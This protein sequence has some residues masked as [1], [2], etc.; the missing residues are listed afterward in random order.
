MTTRPSD[1]PL[2]RRREVA[3]RHQIAPRTLDRALREGPE[4]IRAGMVRD[5]VLAALSELG[6][7]V[8]RPPSAE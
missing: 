6:V 1:L 3:A 2:A 8:E 7:A 5:R 4:A